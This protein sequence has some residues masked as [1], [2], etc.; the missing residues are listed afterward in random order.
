[1]KYFITINQ[2]ILR[3][4]VV[5]AENEQAAIDK[6]DNLIVDGSIDFDCADFGDRDI[7]VVDVAEPDDL[8][9][10]DVFE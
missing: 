3:R 5:E 1:M 9:I 4:V 8:G 6:T 7:N 10:Y 2:Q